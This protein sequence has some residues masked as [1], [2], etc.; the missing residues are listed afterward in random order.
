ME[1]KPLKIATLKISISSQ[2]LE[3]HLL[4][5]YREKY[6]FLPSLL[7]EVEFFKEQF[8]WTTNDFFI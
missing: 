6:H 8:L 1:G 2:F 5:N 7:F 3:A 4:Y